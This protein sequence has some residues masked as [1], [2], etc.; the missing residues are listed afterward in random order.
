MAFRGKNRA[1]VYIEPT[2]TPE[3]GLAPVEGQIGEGIN[4][5]DDPKTGFTSPTGEHGI[6]NNFYRALGCWKNYRGA[7]RTSFNAMGLNEAMRS[8][9]WTGLIVVTGQGKDPMN[10]R[11]VKV[12]I[13]ASQDKIVMNGLGDVNPDFSFRIRPD[14]KQEGIFNGRSVNGRITTAAT[15]EIYLHDTEVFNI[16]GGIRQLLRARADLQMTPSGALEGFIGGYIPWMDVYNIYAHTGPPTESLGWAR[17]PDIYYALRRYA[18]YSPTGPKGEKSHISYAVRVSAKPAYVMKPN[19]AELQTTVVSYKSI[20][21]PYVA[22][23]PERYRY[24][25][26]VPLPDAMFLPPKITEVTAAAQP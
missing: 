10:D 21:K 7:T 3:V 18:D 14:Q 5:D 23:V 4:L 22:V 8:G 11:N 15:P 1:N 13:Y 2:S 17:V 24:K 25:P 6:D 20:A 9:A 16:A 26:L 19:G 12:G